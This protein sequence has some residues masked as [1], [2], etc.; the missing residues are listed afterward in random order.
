VSR[1]G[2]VA[3]AAGWVGLMLLLFWQEFLVEAKWGTAWWF[4][5][6][7]TLAFG[8]VILVFAIECLLSEMT[9]RRW[10]VS[11]VVFVVFAVIFLLAALFNP[12]TIQL[13]R[14]LLI[15]LSLVYFALAAVSAAGA[16][17]SL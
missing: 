17:D 11:V 16:R 15:P 14:W 10:A 3:A 7:A 5:I 12:A 13:S 8:L 6:P 9:V 2:A 1:A 4:R